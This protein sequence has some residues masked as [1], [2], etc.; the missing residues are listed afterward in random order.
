MEDF[1]VKLDDLGRFSVS[2]TV[3]KIFDIHTKQQAYIGYI[4]QK[5]D[6]IKSQYIE[7]WGTLWFMTVVRLCV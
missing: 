7:L 4:Q 6:K 1:L 2:D 5:L 3:S